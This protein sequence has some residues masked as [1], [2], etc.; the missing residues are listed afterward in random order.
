MVCI[1]Y[2]GIEAK[3]NMARVTFPAKERNLHFQPLSL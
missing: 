2:E 3:A 1:I